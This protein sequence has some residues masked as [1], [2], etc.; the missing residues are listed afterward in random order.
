M[1]MCTLQILDHWQNYKILLMQHF[2]IAH[3]QQIKKKKHHKKTS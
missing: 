3:F 2:V 1:L